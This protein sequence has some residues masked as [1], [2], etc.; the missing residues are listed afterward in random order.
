MASQVDCFPVAPSKAEGHTLQT[1]RANIH[2]V[3]RRGVTVHCN[4]V[5]R[6]IYYDTPHHIRFRINS[7]HSARLNQITMDVHTVVFL[8]IDYTVPI[9]DI[10]QI[11]SDCNVSCESADFAS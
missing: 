10:V 9:G 4:A 7:I 6:D 1:S 8:N 5:S 2:R 3:V 11:C